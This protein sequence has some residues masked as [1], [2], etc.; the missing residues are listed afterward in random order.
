VLRV[1]LCGAMPDRLLEGSAI[2]WPILGRVFR[3]E[4]RVQCG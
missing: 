4:Q 1:R 3:C 2:D